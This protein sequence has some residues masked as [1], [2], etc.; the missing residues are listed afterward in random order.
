MRG[1]WRAKILTTQDTGE[2]RRNGE[3]IGEEHGT[4]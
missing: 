1:W 4:N 2:P 3:D